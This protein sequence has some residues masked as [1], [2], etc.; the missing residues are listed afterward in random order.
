MEKELLIAFSNVLEDLGLS[1]EYDTAIDG[2]ECLRAVADNGKVYI[3]Q[4]DE[5]NI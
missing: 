2:G 1:V 3:I 4:V 5:E